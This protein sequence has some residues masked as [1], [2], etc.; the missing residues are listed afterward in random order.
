MKTNIVLENTH[1]PVYIHAYIYMQ[2]CS[3]HH[4]DHACIPSMCKYIPCGHIYIYAYITRCIS[5]AD[6][7]IQMCAYAFIHSCIVLKSG[8]WIDIQGYR[9]LICHEPGL[10]FTQIPSCAHLDLA[11]VTLLSNHLDKSCQIKHGTLQAS[12]VE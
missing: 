12:D 7:Y 9:G 1:I 4:T 2:V 8:D 10:E 3:V 6:T 11:K 5:C